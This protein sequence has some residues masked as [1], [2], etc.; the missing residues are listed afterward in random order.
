ML[1]H[2]FGT[3]SILFCPNVEQANQINQSWVGCSRISNPLRSSGFA[4]V[5]YSKGLTNIFFVSFCPQWKPGQETN[6]WKSLNDELVVIG[7]YRGQICCICISPSFLRSFWTLI[8]SCR[9]SYPPSILPRVSPRRFSQS[10]QSLSGDLGRTM[11][12]GAVLLD[13]FW[14][15]CWMTCYFSCDFEAITW[16]IW[17]ILNMYCSCCLC[18]H[19]TVLFYFV[20]WSYVHIF[21]W[22]LHSIQKFHILIVTFALQFLMINGV[23]FELEF[24]NIWKA[25]FCWT[26]DCGSIS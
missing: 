5:I 1:N 9:V 3:Y 4:A 13:P 23:F 11:G 17:I 19:S 6:K 22:S 25:H 10:L 24:P 20:F 18:W 8:N 2:Q 16:V 15:M 21:S 7:Y 12:W 14:R 26:F